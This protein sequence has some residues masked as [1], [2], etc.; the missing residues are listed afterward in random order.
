MGFVKLTSKAKGE[1]AEA[2]VIATFAKKGYVI[3]KPMGD[4]LR[5]DLVI[6]RGNGFERVQ[7]KSN[8]SFVKE[9]ITF[10][11]RS[12]RINRNKNVSK[13]YNG[14][15]D[16]FAFYSSHLDTVF[17]VPMIDIYHIASNVTLRLKT[18]KNNQGKE[19]SLWANDYSLKS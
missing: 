12:V 18:A 2:V 9:T 3:L 7:I 4:N 19:F 8:W 13:S 11:V 6:D 14:Q 1:I 5:Y 17:L 15:C 10:S 16:L